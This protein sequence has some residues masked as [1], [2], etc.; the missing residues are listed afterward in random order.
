MSNPSTPASPGFEV[1]L[2][3]RRVVARGKSTLQVRSSSI[4]DT[5]PPEHSAYAAGVS[6]ALSWNK[7]DGAQ[8]YVLILE[9]PDARSVR[10][11]VHWVAFNIPAEVTSLPK[12][13]KEQSRLTD[14]KGLL[15]GKN[16]L[17]NVGYFGP[18][19]PVG[20]PPHHYH[21]QVFA[22]DC[23]LDVPPGADRDE[24]IVA[25]AAHVLAAGELVATYQQSVEPLN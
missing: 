22:I 2:A 13:L 20:D 8:S 5:I 14:P 19:P 15:Q 1:P 24:V 16:S 25:M 10:P 3:L 4:Q 6:P 12:G 21:F 11:F 17:G 18:R 7:V 23:K 9:D